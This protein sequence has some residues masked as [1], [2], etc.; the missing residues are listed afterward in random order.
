MADICECYLSS[1]QSK[2]LVV[3][4]TFLCL[5][6]L[7]EFPVSDQSSFIHFHAQGFNSR[8]KISSEF[9]PVTRLWLVSLDTTPALSL[10]AHTSPNSHLEK[11]LVIQGVLFKCSVCNVLSLFS[12]LLLEPYVQT[13]ACTYYVLYFFNVCLFIAHIFW[14]QV[15]DPLQIKAHDFWFF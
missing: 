13:C 4:V 9:P 5:R 11:H 7:W 2:L 1:I 12:S 6:A 14:L 15:Q 8:Y 3:S 10:N